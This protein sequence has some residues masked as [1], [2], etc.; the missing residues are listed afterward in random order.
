MQRIKNS[1]KKEALK[2][3][4]L[5]MDNFWNELIIKEISA[6]IERNTFE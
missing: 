6:L 5:N 4:K 1:V 2:M 3:D